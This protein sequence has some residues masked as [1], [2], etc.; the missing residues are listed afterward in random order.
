MAST[1][2]RS[3]PTRDRILAAAREVFAREGY[4][5][6]TV[7]AVAARADANPALVIRYYGSKDG[8]FAAAA[9][10]DLNLPPLADGPRRQMGQR[11]V[12]HFL[13]RWEQ[14]PRGGELVALLRASA[15]HEGAR[16]RMRQIFHQQ[17]V[18]V[19]RVVCPPRTADARA[20]LIASQMLGL[21]LVRHVLGFPMQGLTPERVVRHVGKT[22]QAYLVDE[23]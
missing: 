21:A 3:Q 7:R 1:S 20:A 11:L 18:T 22:V 19:V 2:P 15:S 17:L 6:S 4:E 13:Q 10:F 23:L 16:E 14:D 8:L 12:A 5:R 9:D